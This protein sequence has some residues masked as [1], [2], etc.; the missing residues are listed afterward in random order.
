MD[1]KQLEYILAI[2]EYGNISRAANALYISQSALNQ[3]LIRL[4][5][6]L[7]MKLFYRDKRSLRPTQAGRIYL[8]NARDIL[9]IKKNTYSRLHD[10]ADSATGEL[11]LGLTW[12]HKVDM[13]AEILPVFSQKYPRFSFKMFERN[14]AQQHQMILSDHLDLG[15]VMLQESERIDANYIPILREELVL[16]VPRSHPLAKLSA[17]VGEPLTY[18]SLALFRDELFSLIYQGSTM[19]NVVDELFREA[20]YQPKIL[21]ETSMNRILHKMVSQGLCC[22]VFPQSYAQPT[23]KVACFRIQGRTY[24]DVC[25]VYP[26][27]IEPNMACKELISLAKEYGSKK[28]KELRQQT[29]V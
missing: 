3:Q 21:F 7:G 19:R 4:E 24:W 2:E 6:D 12:E 5:K 1:L 10:L 25:L 18:I 14:V 23:E 8:D 15:C 27:G 9:T 17:A 20:G 16:A 22:A 26:K 29:P 11:R 13:F 28:E